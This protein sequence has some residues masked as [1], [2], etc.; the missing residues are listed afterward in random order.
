MGYRTETELKTI[1]DELRALPGETEWVEFKEAKTSFDLDKLGEYFSAIANESNLKG[2]E[3]GWIVFGVEDKA[4]AIVGTSYRTSRPALDSL[5]GEIARKTNGGITFIE[6]HEL[7]LPEGR[8]LM[9]E[10]PPAPRGIPVS[11]GGHYY[12]RHGEALSG[13]NIHEIE[14][15]RQQVGIKDWSIQ[16]CER[17]S[18]D[19][20]DPDAIRK[21]RA[22]YKKKH[23]LSGAKANEI[24]AMDDLAFLNKKAKVTC[25]GRITNAAILLLGREDSAALLSPAVAQM[26]WFLKG[27]K[28]DYKHFGPPF[29]L[30]V[31]VLLGK[32]RNLNV[33]HL[34]DGTLF[35]ME[36][37]QYDPWV[38]R[39]AL[40][41]CIA[42]Q[43]YLLGGR[44]TV[45]EH[46]NYLKF[47][48]L[49]R[50]LPGTV[51]NVIE[52]DSPP[53]FYRNHFLADAMV[54][55]NMI[56]T[57]GGGIK[58]MFQSQMRRFFPL[59][60]YDLSQPER[61]EV[62]IFNEILDEK[63]S[64]L[65]MKRTDLDL[66]DVILLDKV[67][68]QV[69]IG[70]GDAAQLKKMGVV[71]GRYPNIFVS[72]EI[73]SLTQ[74][75]A[76]HILNRGFDKKYYLDMILAL[77]REHAPVDREDIDELLM[78]KLPDVF[79]EQKKRSQIHN[80]MSELAYKTFKIKNVGS[81]RY[82][83]WV[84]KPEGEPRD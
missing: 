3:Q 25:Q 62:R 26:S 68:K 31:D 46:P 9:F 48:N 39:E 33:R 11:W 80:L 7:S 65:L 63:Y 70:K 30:N 34:P 15:I 17:A 81:R 56:D 53:E 13:L 71:E 60:D 37:T 84:L 82:P 2:R 5:K 74:E 41:N 28:T 61:V 73:A 76:R 19:D 32:I 47:S 22:E 77:I 16:I 43:D 72:A 66:W 38:I 79:D 78:K 14:T 50:F 54:N 21:A 10:I 69:R 83:K 20:L 24:D 57:E 29:I 18:L 35:P 27:E 40:H 4:H 58:K 52:R 6:I 49:G 12:G 1:L 36:T 44:I 55:L 75:K 45:T 59:P 64:H 42:H 51:E 8:V 67:Q 23:N